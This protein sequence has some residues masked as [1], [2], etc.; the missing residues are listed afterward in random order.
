MVLWW[1][2]IILKVQIY[3]VI[4]QLIWFFM[5]VSFP[6]VCYVKY[7]LAIME[8]CID[9]MNVCCCISHFLSFWIKVLAKWMLMYKRRMYRNKECVWVC[10]TPADT[11]QTVGVKRRVRGLKKSK[12]VTTTHKTCCGSFRH[13]PCPL[14]LYRTG[15]NWYALH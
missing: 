8:V 12:V 3:N 11:A 7:S 2:K 5:D 10:M 1:K 13:I 6:K 15:M 9:S 4:C 14:N